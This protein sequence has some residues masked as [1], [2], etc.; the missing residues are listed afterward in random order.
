MDRL[1]PG[2][3]IFNRWLI[4]LTLGVISLCCLPVLCM[5]LGIDFG[6]GPSVS[7]HEFADPTMTPSQRLGH[8]Y[9]FMTGSFIHSLLEWSAVCVA[10]FIALGAIVHYSQNGQ[11]ST[12]VICLVLVCA[13]AMDAFH[14]LAADRLIPSI[15]DNHSFIPFTWALSRFFNATITIIGVGLLVFTE[16]LSVR[17]RTGLVLTISSLFALIGGGLIVFCATRSQLPA[18]I[19]PANMIA[20]PWDVPSLILF[21]FAALFVIPAALKKHRNIFLFTLWISMIPQIAT[22]LYM[23][24]GSREL[25]D[26]GFNI[27]H[28]TKVLA[29]LMPLFGLFMDYCLVHRQLEQSVRRMSQS[30]RKLRDKHKHLRAVLVSITDAV[31]TVDQTGRIHSV[32]PAAIKVFG[33]SQA[34][35]CRMT[36]VE[37]F[38]QMPMSFESICE[39]FAEN[40]TEHKHNPFVFEAIAQHKTANPIDVEVGVS[41]LSTVGETWYVVAIHDCTQIIEVTEELAMAR[42]QVQVAVAAR[43]R[44]LSN[45][46]F[47]LRTPLNAITGFAALLEEQLDDLHMNDLKEDAIEIRTAAGYLQ[48]MVTDMLDLTAISQGKLNVKSQEIAFNHLCKNIIHEMDPIAQMANNMIHFHESEQEI[49]LHT[50]LHRLEQILLNLLNQAIGHTQD[51]KIDVTVQIINDNK[52]VELHIAD[53]DLGQDYNHRVKRFDVFDHFVDSTQSRMFGLTGM[54][55]SHRL[56]SLLG[57]HIKQEYIQDQGMVRILNLPINDLEV[58]DIDQTQIEQSV[59]M[60]AI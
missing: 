40:D 43:E 45:V 53:N 34:Q 58:E 27:A 9:Q 18:S 39:Q 26:S 50:D 22:Q 55:L 11:T 32:N 24:F 54:S 16:Q 46:G 1:V 33:Y 10:L 57:G 15:A 7:L 5:S 13:G 20:R 37:L 25:F 56:V 8:I 2:I 41:R 49:Y 48:K 29:Y 30:N 35:I 47:E 23:A 44:L 28:F 38:K 31:L 42:D 59:C 17:K 6:N 3:S 51:G 21:V 52:S 4:L 19:F 14:I 60:E 12:P 36:L